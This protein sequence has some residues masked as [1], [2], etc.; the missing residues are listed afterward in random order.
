MGISWT[1]FADWER[2]LGTDGGGRLGEFPVLPIALPLPLV[3]LLLWWWW[4]WS[5]VGG[6]ELELLRW[7][8]HAG[9]GRG[10]VRPPALGGGLRLLRPVLLLLLLLLRLG[11]SYEACCGTGSRSSDRYSPRAGGA[12]RA[13]SRLSLRLS[14]RRSLLLRDRAAPPPLP[15]PSAPKDGGLSRGP[16]RSRDSERRSR[17]CRSRDWRSREARW[18]LSERP[19]EAPR[20]GDCD[21]RVGGGR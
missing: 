15:P 2:P 16:L 12:P 3:L 14:L 18:L 20:C 11:G 17:D 13:R 4:W 6:G 10:D 21:D 7:F 5:S 8:A 1:R 9:A 19:I